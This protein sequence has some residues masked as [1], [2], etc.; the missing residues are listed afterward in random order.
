MSDLRLMASE[1]HDQSYIQEFYNDLKMPIIKEWVDENGEV[2]KKEVLRYKGK[3][4]K[5]RYFLNLD[6]F[7]LKFFNQ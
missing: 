7:I 3:S 4:L 1:R 5:R 2:N 6:Q